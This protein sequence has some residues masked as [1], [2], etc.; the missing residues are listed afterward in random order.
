MN[1]VVSTIIFVALLGVFL[2]TIY[3]RHPLFPKAFDLNRPPGKNLDRLPSELALNVHL[4]LC[5]DI[6]SFLCFLMDEPS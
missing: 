1:R 2:A 5:H 4:D 6:F 3:Y